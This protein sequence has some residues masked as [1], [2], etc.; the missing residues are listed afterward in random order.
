MYNNVKNKSKKKFKPSNRSPKSIRGEYQ[1]SIHGNFIKLK[2]LETKTEVEARCH[3]DDNFD[4]SFG[5]Q[6]AFR[7]L[8][9]VER[10]KLTKIKVGDFVKIVDNEA[11]YTTFDTWIYKNLDFPNVVLYD[12][13]VVPHT[14]TLGKVIAK[15]EHGLFDTQLLAIKTKENKVYLIEEDGVEKVFNKK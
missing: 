9:Q 15:N 14:G 2:N 3:P 5:I 8:N 11:T 6:E 12:F 4:I 10:E 1:L 13:E 7:K